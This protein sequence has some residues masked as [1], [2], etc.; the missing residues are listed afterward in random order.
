MKAKTALLHILGE[1]TIYYGVAHWNAYFNSLIYL[2][3]ASKHPL[4]VVLR[5]ILLLG[6]TEQMGF[7]DVEMGEKIKVV[8]AIKHSVIVV[9]NVSILLLYLLAQRYFISG[10]MIGA[11]KG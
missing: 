3:D 6:Q 8:E 5:N 4:Q 1:S 2:R 10:V 7:N 9:S 11:V